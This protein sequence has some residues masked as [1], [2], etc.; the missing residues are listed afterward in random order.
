MAL[1]LPRKIT[2]SALPSFIAIGAS[3][4]ISVYLYLAMHNKNIFLFVGWI[5]VQAIGNVIIGYLSDHYCRKRVLMWTQFLGIVGFIFALIDPKNFIPALIFLGLFYNPLGVARASLVDNLP[6]VSKVKLISASFIA[7]FLPWSCY[8]AISRFPLFEFGALSSIILSANLLFTWLFFVDI[9]H[10]H[11]RHNVPKISNLVH[12]HHTRRFFW[13]LG[14]LVP[15]S[16]AVALAEVLIEKYPNNMQLY[17]IGGLGV[18]IAA[19]VS[20]LYRKAPHGSVLTISYAVAVVLSVIPILCKL[21]F[22]GEIFNAPYQ[23]IFFTTLWGFYLPFAYDII[24]NTCGTGYRGIVCGAIESI[25]TV[26]S[27]V[28]IVLI[29]ICNLSFLFGVTV[30]PFL[31]LASIIIQKRAE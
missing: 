31:T 6:H 3:Q 20:C 27:L 29:D 19:M 10:R 13:T 30:I 23:T 4:C 8:L 2:L 12:E 28:S 26:A 7:E 18:V 25:F 16:I 21:F 14:A 11:I 5:V 15:I 24:L 22:P 1:A 17:S 9:R